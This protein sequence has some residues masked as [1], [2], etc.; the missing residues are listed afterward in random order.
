MS[1]TPRHAPFSPNQ[2]RIFLFKTSLEKTF[3]T[4]IFLDAD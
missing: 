2:A 3:A 4:R 1:E